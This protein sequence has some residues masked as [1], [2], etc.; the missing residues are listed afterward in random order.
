MSINKAVVYLLVGAA[1]TCILGIW[2]MR[3]G[4]SLRPNR[5]QTIGESLYD[6]IYG[7]IAESS[8]PSKGSRSGS[9]TSRRSFSSSGS[10]T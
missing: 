5:R 8:L 3:F 6:L 7:Q 9:P 10:S 2:I 1:V 4:L